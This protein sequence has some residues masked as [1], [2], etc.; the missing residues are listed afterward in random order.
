MSFSRDCRRPGSVHIPGA[1]ITAQWKI[2]LTAPSGVNGSVTLGEWNDAKGKVSWG[3]EVPS[4][5]QGRRPNRG[6]SGRTPKVILILEMDVK[7]IFY[8]G[9]I[10]N[11]YIHVSLFS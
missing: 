6:S 8:G 2:R 9:K 5:V 10:E 11:A 3:T 4:G 7:L 1:S